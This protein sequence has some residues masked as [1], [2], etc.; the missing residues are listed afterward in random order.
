MSD[1]IMSRQARILPCPNCGQMI[2]SDSTQCRFCSASI[3]KQSAEAAAHVQ[4]QVND[5]CNQAKWIRNMAGA[6]WVFL[7]VSFILTAGTFGVL[8]CFILIPAS[9]V[10]W[11]I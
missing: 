5:A 7:A 2:Y 11:Q 4:E 6:M 10:Y 1:S 8:A 3:D 9:L